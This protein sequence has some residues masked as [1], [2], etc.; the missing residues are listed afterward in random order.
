[1]TPARCWQDLLRIRFRIRSVVGRRPS[2]TYRGATMS[3]A[4]MADWGAN[5]VVTISFLTLLNAIDGVGV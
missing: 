5:F 3:V 2:E 1:M 4:T